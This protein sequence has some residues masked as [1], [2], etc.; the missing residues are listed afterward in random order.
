ME[1]SA[2]L[3]RL[4]RS[5]AAIAKDCRKYSSEP[6]RLTI[7]SLDLALPI[8]SEEC[9][10]P[11]DVVGSLTAGHVASIRAIMLRLMRKARYETEQVFRTTIQGLFS[12][13]HLGGS[14]DR[15]V[16]T[17]IRRAF[18]HRYARHSEAL[19]TR[20]YALIRASRP[21]NNVECRKGITFS[22]VSK[23]CTLRKPRH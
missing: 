16:E 1:E 5:A 17:T 14:P 21:L 3:E 4:H 18:Q 6:H 7:T 10:L 20:L 12:T 19:V 15:D 8:P 13:E 23:I 9:I 2:T 11:R 22:A